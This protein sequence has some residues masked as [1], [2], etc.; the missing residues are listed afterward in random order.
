MGIIFLDHGNALTIPMPGIS[1]RFSPDFSGIS[2][3]SE[4]K[5]SQTELVQSQNETKRSKIG[6]SSHPVS[7]IRPLE[8]TAHPRAQALT[9]WGFPVSKSMETKFFII[10]LSRFIE[11][12]F[13]S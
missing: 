9:R 12:L 8:T 3:A 4:L 10:F 11:N 6:F 5:Y 2:S 1:G 7:T 13:F